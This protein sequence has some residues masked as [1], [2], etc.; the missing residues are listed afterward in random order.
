MGF[1]LSCTT[2]PKRIE[3]L[4]QVIPHIKPKYKYFVINI[5]EEYRRFG[6][7][8]LPKSLLQLCRKNK[9]VVFNFVNDYGAICKYI[10]GYDFMKKKG[11]KNDKLIICDDDTIYDTNLF[12]ELMDEKTPDNITTGSGF[13]YGKDREYIIVEGDA[14]DM[15]EGYAGICFDYS[16]ASEFIEFYIKFYNHANFKSDNLI[17]KYLVASFM[18]DDFILS[19]EYKNKYSNK[20]TRKYVR[21]LDY[22][23]QDDALHKNNI[24]GSNMG[25]YFFLYQNIKVLDTFRNKFILN[26]EIN[27]ISL[28]DNP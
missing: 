3:K 21:P 26:K 20:D 27:S 16:Q 4:V 8:K 1:I 19:N 22:A 15:V 11:L 28:K 17:D 23:F 13:N 18:G 2:T 9:K 14:C 12:Y 10:G 24:F 5:C 7:F 6:K 25:S